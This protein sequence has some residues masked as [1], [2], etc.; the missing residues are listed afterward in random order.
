[1]SISLYPLKFR[2]R[3]K[4]KPWGGQKL[5]TLLGKDIPPRRRIGESWEIADRGK[6]STPVANGEYAGQTLHSLIKALGNSLLGDAVGSKHHLRFPL[7]YKILDVE[8]LL[9]LQ[10]HPPEDYARRHEGEAGKTEMWYVLEADPGASVISGLREGIDRLRFEQLLQEQHIEKAIRQFPVKKGDSIFNPP[11]R[12]H[13]ISPF[14]VMVEIQENSDITYRI[15]DWGR[16]GLNGQPR[17]LHLEQAL[18]VINF[19]DQESSLIQPLSETIGRN[20]IQILVICSAFTVELLRL[21]ESYQDTCQ[22]RSFQVI[23]CLEGKGSIETA[24]S[25]WEIKPGEFVLL[26]AYLG[27]YT[28]EPTGGMS[29]LKSYIS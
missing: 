8:A 20:E 25:R 12:V 24:G 21:Q 23:T 13:A 11:G 27:P 14:C 29:F 7:L 15:H 10:V 28:I 22:G 5:K 1:M 16:R 3:F 19:D 6:D 26:P 2:P 18:A 4:E 9:S 17:P